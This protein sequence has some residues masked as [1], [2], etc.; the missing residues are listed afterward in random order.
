MVTTFQSSA[1]CILW[2][3]QTLV[4]GGRRISAVKAG[5][6]LKSYAMRLSGPGA[7]LFSGP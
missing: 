7:L 3:S 4:M 6:V 5:S 1:T 2:S